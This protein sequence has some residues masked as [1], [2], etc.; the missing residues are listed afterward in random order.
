MFSTNEIIERCIARYID[1]HGFELKQKLLNLDDC[2]SAAEH[3]QQLDGCR[4]EYDILAQ[5]N[6]RLEK[7]SKE[8]VQRKQELAQCC[9]DREKAERER[10]AYKQSLSSCEQ[11][12]KT[13]KAYREAAEQERESLR[14]MVRRTEQIKANLSYYEAAYGELDQVYR[15]Y[16]QLD[17]GL[18]QGLSG[19]FG[20]GDSPLEFFCGALQEQNLARLWDFLSHTFNQ[21][22]LDPEQGAILQKLFDF[23]FAAVNSSQREKQYDRLSDE[24]GG[25]F[26]SR[27]MLRS[28]GSR[29]LGRVQRVL[30]AG[31]THHVSGSIVRQSLVEIG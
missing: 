6:Q 9:S 31:Y 23:C 5:E 29:Q 11:K 14:E 24:T 8:L 18:Q 12:L 16:Q 13:E 20:N 4:K 1:T 2:V 25:G 17:F 19:I 3:K 15:A 27:T 10:D 21:G 30:L 28:S 7:E 26:D 22:G